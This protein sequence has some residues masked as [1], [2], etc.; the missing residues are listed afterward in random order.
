MIEGISEIARHNEKITIFLE[1][2]QKEPRTHLQIANVAK[3]LYMI[4]EADLENI[5]VLIDVGHA[6]MAD[7]N[8]AES[9]APVHR[10][11]HRGIPLGG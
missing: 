3:V 9:V 7:E 11:G 8:L 4:E 10:R 6:W 5:G 2:K 1:Y